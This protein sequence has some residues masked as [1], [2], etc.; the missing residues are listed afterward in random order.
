MLNELPTDCLLPI[1]AYAQNLT[2]GQV[3]RKFRDISKSEIYAKNLFENLKQNLNSIELI[4]VKREITILDNNLENLNNLKRVFAKY[5]ELKQIKGHDTL[6]VLIKKIIE[7][8]DYYKKL[9]DEIDRAI[10]EIKKIVIST[11]I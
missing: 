9:N 10:S 8:N 5:I 7:N 11:R 1:C 6:N 3:N 2:I 4:F